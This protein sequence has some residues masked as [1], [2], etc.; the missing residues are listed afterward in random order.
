M[1][2][3]I[4]AKGSC[5]KCDGSFELVNQRLGFICP[6]CKTTPNKFYL[7]LFYK[8][9]RYRLFADK[10]GQPLDAYRRALNLLSNINGELDEH[11]FDPTKYIRAELEKFYAVNLLERFYKYK[12]PTTAPSYVNAIKKHVQRAKDF[13]QNKDVRDIRK[14]DLI[15]YKEHLEKTGIRKKDLSGKTIKNIMDS[16]KTFMN[17]CKTDLE[18]IDIVPSFPSV[19]L[20][21]YRFKW[22][23]P[24]DQIELYGHVP[25]EDKPIIAFL[26][27]HGCRPSEA[28]ALKV[29]NVNLQ[30]QTVTISATFSGKVYREKRKG[31]KSRSVTIS[32]H[33]ELLGYIT[34][35]I[36]S[37]LPEAWLFTTTSGAFYN[38][39][40]LKKVWNIVREKAGIKKEDLRLYDATRHSFASN[41]VNSNIS[42]FKV[43]RLLGHSTMKMTEKYA[44]HDIENLKADVSTLSLQAKATVTKPSPMPILA[45]K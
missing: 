31:K 19:E 6:I 24:T 37:S 23:S 10:Q 21:E 18:I 9:T 12:L 26:M 32:L 7:D 14:L 41:L 28:R 36:S 20:T 38:E 5:Q 2:G 40:K 16:F 30:N 33:P 27:L 25:D 17:W 22:L 45:R 1:K 42:L 29:K 3:S 44:H 13:F 34:E 4:R 43:S 11:T 35:K 15:N 39:D 8:G